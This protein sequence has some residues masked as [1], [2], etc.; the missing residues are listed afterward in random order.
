V[1]VV[2]G[3][4]GGRSLA[5]PPSRSREVRPTAE[6]VREA[7]FSILGDRV[8]GARVLDLFCGTGALGIE[9]L[10]RGAASAVLVD[11]DVELARRNVK[12]L[13]LEGKA[14]V[15][16]ADAI[17]YLRRGRSRFDLVFCDPPYRLA[18]RLGPELD[19]LVPS[20]LRGGALVILE[21]SSRKPMKL[22]LDLVTDRR[23]GEASVGIY[24][25]GSSS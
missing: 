14:E 5:S 7:I 16:R 21:S 10:S 12:A 18:D 25:A 4:L 6:R 20:R 1:R 2:G 19:Q 22:D 9:A 8:G 11:R 13:G 17:A 24:A 15:E 23:Y 3:E